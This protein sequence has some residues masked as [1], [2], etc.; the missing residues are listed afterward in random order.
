[1][2]S[3]WIPVFDPYLGMEIFARLAV[4]KI[5]H[6][7]QTSILTQSDLDSSWYFEKKKWIHFFLVL[8]G[9]QT[10]LSF[11]SCNPNV[12]SFSIIPPK[13]DV[14]PLGPFPSIF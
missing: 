13:G 2:Q 12:H 14:Y 3:W 10:F 7:C 6:S 9:P 4:E 1:M 5:C 8:L 11:P